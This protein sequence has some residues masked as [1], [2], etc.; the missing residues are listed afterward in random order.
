[1]PRRLLGDGNR[2]HDP[3]VSK[4]LST[5]LNVIS[6]P[7]ARIF[8]AAR[9]RNSNVL[10]SRAAEIERTYCVRD[11]LY[12][13]GSLERGVTV[14]RQQVRAH[15][16][17]WALS[18]L[19][20]ENEFTDPIAV[21]GG[22]IA[23]L[24]VAACFLS[25]FKQASVTVFEQL[26]DLCPLQQG[27]DNRWLH[28]RIYDWPATGSR[29]PSASLPVLNWSEGRASDVAR[30]VL[31]EFGR[32]SDHFGE[33]LTVYL[34]LGHLRI[35][36][37]ENKID[38]VGNK[39]QRNGAFFRVGAPEG[40]SG[41]FRLIILACGFGI[42]STVPDYP[43]ASYWRN[44]QIGQPILDGTRT[45]F[46]I[47]G[48]GDGA[49]TDLFRLTIE[50][51][52]QD[53][54]LYELFDPDLEK[55]EEHFE[56]AW[57]EK[58]WGDNAFQLFVEAEAGWLREAQN[59]LSTRIRKDT[60]VILHIRGKQGDVKSFPQIF[61]RTSSFLNRLLT[62]LL[63]RCGAFAI[64][65]D[66]LPAAVRRHAVAPKN[67]LCRY[68]ADTLEHLRRIFVDFDKIANRLQELKDTQPQV[69]RLAWEPGTFPIVR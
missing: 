63:Y 58:R 2:D 57:P 56:E 24:T 9:T 3:K 5:S 62:F 25:L 18:D 17:T 31:T 23:G 50:R 20:R 34:G 8:M 32:L 39:G 16:L 51:F 45:T 47:S 65:F 37:E 49:L 10:R 19:L 46:L 36:A 42:E 15:N 22:G 54:I 4:G 14:Y 27:A 41:R 38:W 13:L 64:S 11:G 55:I 7:S 60:R 66:E 61:N 21:V 12:L 30:T 33:R 68:G 43:T 53:T 28:P 6:F 1:V 29:A 40:R 67:V 35:S 48:F 69:T 26:W 44:E 59:R 52:R